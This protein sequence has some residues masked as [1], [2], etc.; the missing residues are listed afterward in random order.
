MRELQC[1]VKDNEATWRLATARSSYT[2]SEGA[3]LLG[4]NWSHKRD[5]AIV[6]DT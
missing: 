2:R 6:G 4:G 3:R 1:Q 5:T